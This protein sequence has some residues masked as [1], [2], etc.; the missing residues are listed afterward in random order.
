MK[1]MLLFASAVALAV[2]SP[3]R[4]LVEPG[5]AGPAPVLEPIAVGPAVLDFEPIASGPG[6]VDYEPVAVGPVP[7]EPELPIPAPA[8]VFPIEDIV[9]PVAPAANENILV[10][11]ILNINGHQ[12]SVPEIVAPHPPIEMAP[13]DPVHV[14][15]TA[16]EPVYVGPVLVPEPV[17]I[18][19]PV[20]PNP[21]VILPEELN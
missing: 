20:L 5:A 11:I 4:S 13:A 19:V 18:G 14:V 15:D 16:P 2:A 21:A 1:Y 12:V 10:Q 9:P 3:Q 7:V 8:P 6:I 17:A